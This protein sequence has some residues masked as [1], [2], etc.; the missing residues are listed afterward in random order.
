MT[1][2]ACMKGEAGEGPSILGHDLSEGITKQLGTPDEIWAHGF[3][4]RHL[5][6]AAFALRRSVRRRL[7]SP[8]RRSVGHTAYSIDQMPTVWPRAFH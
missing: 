8:E 1:Q 6:D 3:L 7:S 4:C 2:T 5:L